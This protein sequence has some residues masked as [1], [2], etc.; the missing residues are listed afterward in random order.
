MIPS[1][2]KGPAGAPLSLPAFTK[3]EIRAMV[4]ERN[5]RESRVNLDQLRRIAIAVATLIAVFVGAALLSSNVNYGYGIVSLAQGAYATAAANYLQ[6]FYEQDTVPFKAF[7]S[8]SSPPVR[9]HIQL[10]QVCLD[11]I[12]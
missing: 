11:F 3:A 8:F 1:H 12:C 5:A 10:S 7:Q 6:D 4:D 9:K 2:P